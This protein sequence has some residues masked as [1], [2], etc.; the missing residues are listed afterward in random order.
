MT[1][2]QAESLVDVQAQPLLAVTLT[3]PLPPLPATLAVVGD[4]LN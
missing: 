2:A 1:D 3:L 4:R